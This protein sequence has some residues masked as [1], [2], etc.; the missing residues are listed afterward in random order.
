V[1][2]VE[3]LLAR[4]GRA[5]CPAETTVFQPDQHPRLLRIPEVR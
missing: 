1:G 5:N 3:I 4:Y 2:G